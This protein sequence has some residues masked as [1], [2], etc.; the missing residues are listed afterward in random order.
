MNEQTTT[1]VDQ[2]KDKLLSTSDELII[3]MIQEARDEALAEAKALLKE[4]NA[5]GDSRKCD[6]RTNSK[7]EAG[8]IGRY[9]V[10]TTT[11]ALSRLLSW[12]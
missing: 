2:L 4:R 12:L 7:K 9:M 8:L 1:L 11:S 5:S 10:P 6:R 3:K